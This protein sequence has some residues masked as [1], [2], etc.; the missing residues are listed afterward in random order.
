MALGN[1]PAKVLRDVAPSLGLQEG[2]VLAGAYVLEHVLG[3]G[4]GGVVVRAMRTSDQHPVAIKLLRAFDDELLAHRLLREAAA[5]AQMH[6]HHFVEVFELGRLPT[7]APFIVMEYLEGETLSARFARGQL[8]LEESIR[9]IL[10]VCEGLAAAHGR[11]IVHRDIKPSNIFLAVDG[12]GNQTVKILDLGVSMWAAPGSHAELTEI[13]TASTVLGTPAFSSPE[14]LTSPHDVDAR[15]DVWSLGVIL[16]WLLAGVRPFT[17]ESLPQLCASV[18]NSTPARLD[19]LCT[20]VPPALADV[21]VRCL[22]KNRDQRFQDVFAL[23]R[24]LAPFGRVG[25]PHEIAAPRAPARIERPSRP[26][27][28]SDAVLVTGPARQP[29]RAV[30]GVAIALCV[31]LLAAGLVFGA[32][33]RSPSSSNPPSLGPAASRSE[34]TAEVPE[35]PPAEISAA[36]S[37]TA[38]EPLLERPPPRPRPRTWVKPAAGGHVSVP[39]TVPSSAPRGDPGSYR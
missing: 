28:P 29:T 34:S 19:E 1:S 32:R 25:E 8:T 12:L 18:F 38:S 23:S 13:T 35:K 15:T 24:A 20:H 37:P 26:G 36:P 6:D 17:G 4:G 27:D 9:C 10:E 39:A 3:V 21:V 31:I 11:G 22:E 2:S 16:Y 30:V 33:G 7:G 5:A 14:Q